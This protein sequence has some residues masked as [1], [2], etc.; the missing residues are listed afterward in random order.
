M[1]LSWNEIR[2]R[3]A[4]FSRDWCDARYEKSDTQSF[5]NDFFAIFGVKRRR[6]ARF[7]E[8][9]T[10]L[11]NSRGYIDLFWPGVLLVEQKSVGRD[12]N[13]AAE[14]AG[15]YFDAVNDS[16][17][18]R[19][20]LV[21]DFQTFHLLDRET[22]GQWKFTLEELPQNVE[23]FGFIL[24]RQSRDFNQQDSVSIAATELVGQIHDRLA[25]SGY[26]AD[27]LERF[28]VQLVF[29]LF[30]DDTGIF[31]P[32]D[33]FHNLLLDH[34]H[35][36]GSDTGLWLKRLFELLNTP[37]DER[38]RYLID[39]LAAFPYVD[40]MLF[41]HH[42]VTADF[43]SVLRNRLLEACEYDWSEISPAIF[44]SLF[45]CVMDKDLRRAIGAHYT[46]EEN[47]LKVIEPLFLDDLRKEFSDICK[48]KRGQAYRLQEFQRKL[49]DL[50]FF[51]PACGC[52]NFLVIAYRELRQ[53]EIDVLRQRISSSQLDLDARSLSIVDVDQFYGIELEEFPARIAEIA[54]WMMDHI[55][56][57]R[58]GEA[59]G[60]VYTRIP[61][62]ATANIACAD[63]LEMDWNDVISAA[64]C[65]YILGNPPF[66]GSK[67]Q[68]PEQR[69][70]VH[71]IAA[72]KHIKGTLDYVSCWF[73][74]AAAYVE[75]KT[76][77]GLV[78]TNSIVQGE[79]VGQL[80]PLMFNRAGLDI[81][82]AHS[83]FSWSS[84]AS[85]AA[86]VHVVIIGLV[87]SEYRPKSVRLFSYPDNT[88]R[89]QESSHKNIS[90]YLVPELERYPY[91]AVQASKRPI[92]GFRALKAGSKPIDDGN[93]I[94]KSQAQRDAFV[95]R[96]P[97]AAQ[98]IRPYV[99]SQDLINGTT[100]YILA[101]HDATPDQLANLP[102]VRERIRAVREFR[103]RS[104]SVPTIKL[105]DTPMLY[106]INV[107]PSS[108]FLVIPVTS[109]ERREY[110]PISWLEPPVIPN[111]D[112]RILVDASLADFAL[113]TSRMHM[114]WLRFVGGRLESRYRY[115]INLVYNVFPRPEG[116][117]DRLE[118]FAK[119]VLDARDQYPDTAFLNLY[120]PDFMPAG[121]RTAHANLD[122]AV[123]RLYRRRPFDSDQE[124]IDCL[125]E[126]YEQY[127]QPLL[128]SKRGYRSFGRNLPSAVFA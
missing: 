42:L 59:F 96:E 17:K 16:E 122:R 82:F 34:T 23:V 61:L 70:Q 111:I 89:P 106:H 67:L 24:G 19:Y 75:G 107:I 29:C 120:D 32:R 117:L 45:Q 108:A 56:N 113:L 103:Q 46:T 90:P 49:G 83:S 91:V 63:A 55:M 64:N 100:R 31:E 85:G 123:E 3:A 73:L 37:V 41:E 68:S 78:A 48:L 40:G 44:G 95:A 74:K 105:A 112:T 43:D 69:A 98:F 92:N 86:H 109:S 6:V 97:A 88:Q 104:S 127:V 39:D 84:E 53:L 65:S 13:Q 66:S 9:V 4:E 47:I 116:D 36:D 50:T 102:Q 18:P 28:L 79:Q 80:W 58:L 20:Q 76:R 1:A 119:A 25:H 128:I 30:A 77:I 26:P 81:A 125:F 94:F 5:Y 54:L 101:L 121:L 124:R 72:F 87:R 14:Q 22:R 62:R 99:G 126:R 11:D 114:V 33:I 118:P 7:E 35:E 2:I 60:K 71:R 12:L 10:R 15:E 93:Y 27:D 52:G 38:Q 115:S 110:V 57:N 21:C 51:D 8:R